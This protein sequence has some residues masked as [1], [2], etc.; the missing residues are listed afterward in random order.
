VKLAFA[1]HPLFI[2]VQFVLG[3][4]MIGGGLA[5]G[6]AMFERDQCRVASDDL[7]SKTEAR[8]VTLQSRADKVQTRE[9]SLRARNPELAK[10]L[11][12][13]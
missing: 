5:S 2:A 11:H 3:L 8:L 13:P 6:Y 7:Q 12:A 1:Q 4:A 10:K 9:A